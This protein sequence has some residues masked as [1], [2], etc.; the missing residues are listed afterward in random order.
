[1]EDPSGFQK[2]VSLV[3]Y[4]Q[5]IEFIFRFVAKSSEPLLALGVVFSAAD[6]LSKGTLMQG[7][8]SLLYAWA[9]AQ[10]IAIESSGGV[11]L[12]YALQSFK[13]QDKTKGWLYLALSVLLSLVG[14]VMLFTQLIAN[15]SGTTEFGASGGVTAYIIILSVFRS[16]VSIGYIVMCRTKHISF[17]NLDEEAKPQT[18]ETEHS[19][20]LEDVKTVVFDILSAM[21][22]AEQNSVQL[23]IPDHTTASHLQVPVTEKEHNQEEVDNSEQEQNSQNG[24][25]TNNVNFE[26][27][28]IFLLDRPNAKVR[29]VAAALEMSPSTANK[30]MQRVRK[31]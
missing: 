8:S 17:I 7:N 10:A 3:W 15:T 24:Q 19:L 22:E 31:K 20:T 28:K 25:S 14:G 23:Q 18:T 11:V 6:V 27:V 30:W 21:K 13:L 1:M 12:V 26:R 16:I 9:W 5:L 29:E 2:F 4:D